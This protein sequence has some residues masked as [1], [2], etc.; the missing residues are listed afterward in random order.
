M[1]YEILR[2]A[3]YARKKRGKK[4]FTSSRQGFDSKANDMHSALG[5]YSGVGNPKWLRYVGQFSSQLPIIH[6][7]HIK[8]NQ[9]SL[10]Y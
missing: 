4:I 6:L 2:A 5:C 9:P 1:H 7:Y 10:D 8:S 3:P